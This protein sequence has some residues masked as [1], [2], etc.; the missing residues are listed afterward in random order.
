MWFCYLLRNT[1]PQHKS[2]TYN[3]STNNPAR[4][5]RQHN[6]ELVGGAKAT[7]RCGGGWEFCA[8]LSGFDSHKNCLSCEWRIKCPSGR[9]GRRDAKYRGPMGRVASLNEVLPLDKWTGPCTVFNRDQTLKLCVLREY[10]DQL[11][12]DAIPENIHVEM[13]DTIDAAALGAD[14]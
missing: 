14:V 13:V 11:H 6:G 2:A 5:L 12:L 8:L 3:G 7:A 10:M 4:R 9:P 1:Q